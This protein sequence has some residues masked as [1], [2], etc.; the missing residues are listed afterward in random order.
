MCKHVQALYHWDELESLAKQNTAEAPGGNFYVNSKRGLQSD[1]S[2]SAAIN[3]A[4]GSMVFPM[5]P[6]GTGVTYSLSNVTA[7]CGASY[8]D[9]APLTRASAD[10]DAAT[11][12]CPEAV[13]ANQRAARADTAGAVAV[14]GGG[15]G[16]GGGGHQSWVIPVALTLTFG[17]FPDH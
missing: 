7:W 4:A 14:A 12:A 16:G 11:S 3:F 9:A 13:A 10:A 15:G 17:T 6:G 8:A 5:Q 2:G 1:C